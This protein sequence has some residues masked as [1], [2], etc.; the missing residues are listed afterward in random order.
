MAR[1]LVVMGVDPGTARTG[2]GVVA[3]EGGLLSLVACGLIVT[4]PGIPLEARLLEIHDQVYQVIQ[5]HRPHALAV[6][7]LF[8]GKNAKTASSVGQARGAV[9]VAAARSRVPVLEYA[10]LEVK[11]AL[12]GYGRA[13]KQQIQGMVKA[14]LRLAEAP[15]PDDVA[16]AVA[17]AVCC[18]RRLPESASRL[19][20]ADSRKGGIS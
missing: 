7:Q 2:Y 3:A 14:L 19:L 16:D 6:E 15:K 12:V 13:P 11:M 1:G 4:A 18:A 17:V 20:N 5:D 10:P 8:F 9:L